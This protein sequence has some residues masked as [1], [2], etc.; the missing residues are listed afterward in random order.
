MAHTPS[1]EEHD[2]N[3]I[4]IS[5][6]DL[7]EDVF[8]MVFDYLHIWE[9]AR[10][11][12]VSKAWRQAFSKDEYLAM[13]L[14]KHP[15][16]REL[17]GRNSPDHHELISPDLVDLRKSFHAIA[18]RYY[19]ISH[20]KSRQVIR[21]ELAP[22]EQ[23]GHFFQI[24]QWDYHESQPG[25]RLY[26]ENAATHL[27]RLTAKPCLFHA[28]L[29]SYS[30]GLLVFAPAQLTPQAKPGEI[31]A[32]LDLVTNQL[33]RVPFDISSRVIRNIRLHDRT[34]IVEWAERDPFHNLNDMEQVNRHFAS[35]YSVVPS[36]G[37]DDKASIQW[38]VQH[39]SEFKLHFLGLPLN[40][41]DRFFSTHNS[42]HYAIYFF[43]PNRSMYS[44]D[45]DL[46]IELLFVWDIS[47]TSKYRP[48]QDPSG[49]HRPGDSDD[50]PH[51]LA[52]F[53]FNDLEFLGIRQHSQIRL[54]SLSL[55]TPS[56]SLTWREN[57][58]VA[59]QGYF[60]PAERLWCA[61]TTSLPFLGQGPHLQREWDGYLP[62]YRGHSSM[63]SV[64]L[65]EESIEKWFVP[66]M[67]AVDD[68][69]G[70]RLSLVETCFTG[71]VVENKLIIRLKL[72]WLTEKN[73]D[74]EYVMLKDDEL[75]REVSAMGRIA[76]DERFLIG[77]NEQMQ[78]VVVYF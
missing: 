4:S 25:G 18:S 1:K 8:F 76:G 33:Y 2:R 36:P 61:K 38:V 71:T 68:R 78:L 39:R 15:L 47:K 13:V 51:I 46:P 55:D 77:Q 49:Q 72:P 11:Q 9:V 43:Q 30:D 31:L 73:E 53:P 52:R 3:A 34:L 32:V 19:H 75:V 37:L 26:P 10:C 24:G 69:T 57:V 29:W 44:G 22:S 56:S 74:G 70:V 7:P 48:S 58:C 64:D 40:S 20:G 42:T 54:M 27:F 5:V 63:E 6:P 62:P 66:I 67:D 14:K 60:D 35:C 45:E 23:T 65:D 16:A 17:D 59:G 50:G 21:H 12:L 28:S 41:R